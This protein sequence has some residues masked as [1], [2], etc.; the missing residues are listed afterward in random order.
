MAFQGKEMTRVRLPAVEALM[1][2]GAL[3]A[4]SMA[5]L[6]EEAPAP[7]NPLADLARAAKLVPDPVEPKDF[8]KKTRPAS[9]DFLPIGIV[10]KARDVKVKTP[11][12]VKAMEQELDQARAVQ[13]R[14][15]GRKPPSKPAKPPIA[16]TVKNQ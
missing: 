6:A 2:V 10:P 8:V 1:V 16:G 14:I 5:G 15:A 13:D 4:S 12:E 9:T 11:A 3:V 7:T